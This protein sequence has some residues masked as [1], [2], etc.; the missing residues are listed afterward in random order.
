M[1][2]IQTYKPVKYRSLT[3]NYIL[4]MSGQRV[5]ARHKCIG[6]MSYGDQFANRHDIEEKVAFD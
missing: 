2:I 6:A 4:L 1:Y 5:P 3:T